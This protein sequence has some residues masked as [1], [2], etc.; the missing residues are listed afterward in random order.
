[1]TGTV[2]TKRVLV[3]VRTYPVPARSG[4][5]VSCTAGITSEGEWIRLFPIPYRFLAQDQRF[6]KYQWIDVDV[7]KATSD[8]RPESYHV[9]PDSIR[10][11]DPK[12]LVS[13]LS[14]RQYLAAL[15][16]PSMEYLI[17]ARDEHKH[18]TLGIFKPKEILKLE[19]QQEK[20][21][22]WTATQLA[23]LR[24]FPMF[25]TLPRSELVKIPY[26]WVYHYICD[27][28]ECST[29]HKMSC[30]DWEMG[31]SY[32]RWKVKYGGNWESKFRE[33]YKTYMKERYDTHFYV[34]TVHGHPNNWIIVGLFRPPKT[35][36]GELTLEA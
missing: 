4:I 21:P 26:R 15:Q 25:G 13:W 1:M 24:Q 18:P 23:K 6:K 9:N 29:P 32:L 3:T 2:I 5:E 27:D 16:A 22:D 36:Q 8:I 19:I 11:V 35:L 31:V 10:I 33:T 7:T 34:G 12:P 20:E 30:T 28:L 17:K 14:K